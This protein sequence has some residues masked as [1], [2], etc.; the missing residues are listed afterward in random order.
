MKK[1]FWNQVNWILVGSWFS[2]FYWIVESIRDVFIFQKGSLLERIFFPD[3]ITFWMR[4]LVVCILILFGAY[5]DSFIEK[6]Q[7]KKQKTE[8]QFDII[9]IGLVFGAVYWII[10]SLRIAFMH[11]NGSLLHCFF[12][13]DSMEF[14]N[15]ILGV[16]IL[17]FFSVYMQIRTNEK[18][19][20]LAALQEDEILLGAIIQDMPFGVVICEANG[21]ASK[22]NKAFL[23]T[24]QIKSV[25]SFVKKYN[26][27]N[28]P[29]LEN[30]GLQEKVTKAFKG[31]KVHIPEI[32]VP[33]NLFNNPTLF[34]KDIMYQQVTFFPVFRESKKIW[35][36]VMVWDNITDLIRTKEEKEDIQAQLL[37]AQKMEAIGILAGGIAHDFNNILTSIHG[38]TDLAMLE[39]EENSSSFSDLKQVKNAAMRA[40]NLT[41]QLLY[42][43]RKHPMEFVPVDLNK[44]INDLLNMLDRL[45]SEDVKIHTNLQ[46]NLWAIEADRGT[47]EQVVMNLAVN[48]HTAMPYGGELTITTENIIINEKVKRKNPK[49]EPGRFVRMSV[50]DTGIG[51]EKELLPHIFEPFFSTRSKTGGT[52]L[53]LSV[54]HGI[55]QQH[56][57]WITVNSEP[58]RGTVFQ[59]MLPATLVRP[60][61][62]DDEYVT[63]GTLRGNNELILV[64][65]D[66]QNVSDFTQRALEKNGY[67][68]MTAHKCSEAL[69]LLQN[70][71]KYDLILSDVI[72]GDDTGITLAEKCVKKYPKSRIVLTS[73]YMDQKSQWPIINK[74]GFH[75]IQK[76]Y[77]LIDLLRAVQEALD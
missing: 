21:T 55:V 62:K 2:L 16:S 27:F 33:S 70:G 67:Q 51:I 42:F 43:S 3:P 46:S 37:Q 66:D 44:S 10:Q 71:K 54:V 61:D 40:S 65:E 24:F 31:E 11:Y 19:Q 73:G 77:S 12:R 30:L 1:P 60:S 63:V 39:M 72:L 4:I 68:V 36:V 29:L 64:V 35:R 48:A 53:G 75:F 76:P 9:L 50:S 28:D 7:E 26:I 18:R 23:K 8:P 56:G 20:F 15:R 69:E 25:D 47:I 58:G 74:K 57:G 34:S 22:V 59:V 6:H 32:A 41:R 45:I 5:V 13:P 14:W 17:L 38:G 52:G 49:E